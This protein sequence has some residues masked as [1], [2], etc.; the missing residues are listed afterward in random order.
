MDKSVKSSFCLGTTARALD[1]LAA[2]GVKNNH[3]QRII[4]DP[5]MRT[6]VASAFTNPENQMPIRDWYYREANFIIQFY[7]F[8]SEKLYATREKTIKL[9]L[10]LLMKRHGQ[11]GY[12]IS[13][14]YFIPGGVDIGAIRQYLAS[15]GVEIQFE[16]SF[17]DDCSSNFCPTSTGILH[18]DEFDR[19]MKI[20]S[21]YDQK[22][23]DLRYNRGHDL[24]SLEEVLM[25]LSHVWFDK[26]FSLDSGTVWCRDGNY[27]CPYATV[28]QWVDGCVT[29][30]KDNRNH[31][32]GA[33][34][35]IFT[36]VGE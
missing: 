13:S 17:N 10:E 35:R 20:E 21:S 7:D 1:L 2:D 18:Y 27:N 19:T 12:L 36:P 34:P 30:F 31:D 23:Q 9:M 22:V 29:V 25:F 6:R 8:L 32:W 11:V 16:S 24:L 26:S 14:D 28:V 5:V 33:I 3:L 4:D 15:I